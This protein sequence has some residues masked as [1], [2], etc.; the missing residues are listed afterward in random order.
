MALDRV[1]E[2]KIPVHLVAVP[3]ALSNPIDVS[4]RLELRNDALD[5]PLGDPYPLGNV[6]HPSL[7]ILNQAKQD[8]GMVGE[9]RPRGL[10]LGGLAACVRH[11]RPKIHDTNFASQITWTSER[12]TVH[13]PEGLRSRCFGDT[14]T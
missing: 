6:T 14:Q 10:L 11:S 13:G 2:W 9:K 4:R 8:M 5:G 3:A 1:A 7:R 12:P